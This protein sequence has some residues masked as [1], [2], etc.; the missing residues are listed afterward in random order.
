MGMWNRQKILCIDKF[1][2]FDFKIMCEQVSIAALKENSDS[3]RLSARQLSPFL[4]KCFVG[5]R[6]LFKGFRTAFG[7]KGVAEVYLLLEEM[8]CD[9]F[10]QL[11]VE[12][13]RKLK[14]NT[15][16]K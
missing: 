14:A 6:I 2:V 7:R 5:F 9:K 16:L 11:K 15:S 12:M 1:Y 4:F 10:S 3:L 8:P 13:E